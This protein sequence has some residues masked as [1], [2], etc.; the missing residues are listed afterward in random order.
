MKALLITPGVY[1]L[2]EALSAGLT[3]NE[4]DFKFVDYRKELSQLL[5]RLYDKTS[6]FP[7]RIN[8]KLKLYFYSQINKKYLQVFV[9]YQPDLVFIYNNQFVSPL[10]IKYFSDNHAKVIFQLGDNP[11]W[12]K[13]Y[14]HNLEIL[15][16]ADL[17]ICPDSYW[18]FELG[19]IGIPHVVCDFFGYSKKHF[20]K[21]SQIPVKIEEKYRSELLFIG[22]NYTGSAGYKRAKFLSCFTGRDFKLFG[23]REWVNWLGIFPELKSH[24]TRL[25]KRISHE[26]LN[27]AFN[28]TKICPIDQN[29]GIIH[30]IHLRVFESIGAGTLPL[31]EWRKDIDAVFGNLLPVIKEYSKLNQIARSF[32]ESDQLREGTISVLQNFLEENYTPRL[33]VKRI[34][35]RVL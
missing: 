13:T 8:K 31:V 5:N 29:P 14:E 25:E 17:V 16:Q 2:T 12:S 20:H 24:F 7:E 27:Q 9:E 32:L 21:I 11:L 6:G 30:G 10:T 23:T 1:T 34:L 18:K 26:E 28:C 3:E 19:M 33:Y 15:E 22:R 4:A 35:E